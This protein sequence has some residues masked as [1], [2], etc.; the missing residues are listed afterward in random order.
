M[1]RLAHETIAEGVVV[2]VVVVVAVVA[3]VA[4][5]GR[6]ISGFFSSCWS[7]GNVVSFTRSFSCAS[8]SINPSSAYLFELA[9]LGGMG[10]SSLVSM[11]RSRSFV[12]GFLAV[13]NVD[14]GASTFI[15]Q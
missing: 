4:V 8:C 9:G 15:L 3:V 12:A 7:D 5:A 6:V 11:W 2:V 14:P 1:S 10:F 13:R